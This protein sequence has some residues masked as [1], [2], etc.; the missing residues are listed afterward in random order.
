MSSLYIVSAVIV[1]VLLM[2]VLDLIAWIREVR[3]TSTSNNVDNAKWLLKQ[4]LYFKEQGD[5][6]SIVKWQRDVSQYLLETNDEIEL[7][8]S[9]NITNRKV[10]PFPSHE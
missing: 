2:C 4:Y 10:I 3:S 1:L 7:K 6:H 5:I 9:K 8:A